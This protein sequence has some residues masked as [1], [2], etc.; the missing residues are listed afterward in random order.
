[1]NWADPVIS[2]N[3]GNEQDLDP[4]LLTIK[5]WLKNNREPM[6]KDFIAQSP[7]VKYLKK[8]SSLL[9]IVAESLFYTWKGNPDKQL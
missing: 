2:E 5:Q 6:S 7:D 3:L 8:Q 1:M 9:S 4:C